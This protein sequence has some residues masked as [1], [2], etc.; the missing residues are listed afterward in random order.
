MTSKIKLNTPN[1]P[2]WADLPGDP[3]AAWA[4]GY[5]AASRNYERAL[6]KIYPHLDYATKNILK[7]DSGINPEVLRVP[8]RYTGGRGYEP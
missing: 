3:R 6:R 4:N 5:R 8:L 7:A 1:C 2:P